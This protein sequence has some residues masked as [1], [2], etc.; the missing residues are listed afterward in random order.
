LRRHSVCLKYFK[1]DFQK[2]WRREIGVR[3]DDNLTDERLHFEHSK[4]KTHLNE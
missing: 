3:T 2:E 1:V 4:A